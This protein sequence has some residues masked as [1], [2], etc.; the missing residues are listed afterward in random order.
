M[1]M[2][3]QGVPRTLVISPNWIGD[4]V[5]AQPLL[6][7]LRDRHPQRPIDV[8]AP[9]W[10]APVWRAMR[11][12]DI[13]LEAPFRHGA[14]QLRER[15]EYAKMLKQ[16]GYADAYVLPNTLKFALIPWLAGIPRRVGYKGEMRYGLLNVIHHDNR[17]KPRPMVSFYA[18]LAEV[19]RAEV[20]PPSALPRPTLAVPDERVA[21][22]MSR[23]G[24]R[25]D[26]PLLLFAPGAEFGSAKRWPTA[27][28]AELARTVQ[29]ERPE[30]QIALMG[31]AKDSEVCDEITALA[32]GLRNL[33]GVTKLDEAVALIARADAM[34]SN[35]SGLLHIA[36][37]LNRP[38]VAIYGPTDPN[39]AP[40]FS[41]V[42]K[43]L[44][45]GLDCAPCKQREC[46]LGHHRCMKE[47]SARMVWGQVRG[48]L[49]REP[50]H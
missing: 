18:A 17:D 31:S 40:P 44:Y 15:R 41:D 50:R 28:F 13:V 43:S 9:A 29:R 7:L 39:H 37:A 10:V 35:D 12:V 16:R 36:S 8:L 49:V 32:P 42:A 23:A 48:M 14:L 34:V 24:L 6:R 5:M 45:L 19:P 47:I 30:T 11:E 33:A 3:M 21:E 27:H 26:R 20:P 38:I 2:P 4:A 25:M 22:V 1:S 46:P